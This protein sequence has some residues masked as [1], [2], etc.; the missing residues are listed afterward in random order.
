MIASTNSIIRGDDYLMSK[1]GKLREAALFAQ[2]EI[3]AIPETARG[4]EERDM[5]EFALAPSSASQHRCAW[6]RPTPALAQ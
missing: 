1:F 2:A 5:I 6:L 3:S 4:E